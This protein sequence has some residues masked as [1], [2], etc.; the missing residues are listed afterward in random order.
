MQHSGTTYFEHPL[1]PG[2]PM[3]RCDG[4]RA[5]LQVEKCAEMWREANGKTPPE[6]LAKC[7]N[8]PIGAAHAGEAEFDVSVLRGS[9][10]CSRCHRGGMRLIGADICV[11][12]WNRA[13]EVVV[14]RNAKGK[15]PSIHP[16]MEPRE[17]RVRTGGETIVIKRGLSISTDELVVAALRDCTRQAFFAFHASRGKIPISIQGELF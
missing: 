1:M 15:P 11:S 3:F 6:R 7:R 13:R 8:C 10:I 9:G 5:D 2:R 16:P 12:C 14:G 17:I 4:M